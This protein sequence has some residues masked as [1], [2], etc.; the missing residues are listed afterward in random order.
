MW[1]F[2][3]RRKDEFAEVLQ[4]TRL[5]RETRWSREYEYPDGSN[6]LLDSRFRD[7]SA[8]I[9]Y[10]QLVREWGSWRDDEKLDFCQS[11]AHYRG[12]GCA[13]MLRFIIANGN[14]F[15]WQTIAIP[16]ALTLPTNEAVAFLC[17]RIENS[18]IGKRANYF[19]GCWIT[20]SNDTV[21]ILKNA[22]NQIWE[23][24][25]LMIPDSFCNWVTH[26]AIWCIDALVRLGEPREQLS[27][28]Y[29]Q[30]TRHSTMGSQALKWLGEHFDKD[31]GEPGDATERKWRSDFS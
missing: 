31:E 26:D 13:T 16:V 24:P 15:V 8:T 14:D 7:G 19:Q 4:G 5:V 17:D 25:G 27:H 3:R 20:R 2:G 28:P 23:S 29:E 12:R 9:G 10:R 1:P 18:E 6:A 30:L 11:F 21:P 22:L